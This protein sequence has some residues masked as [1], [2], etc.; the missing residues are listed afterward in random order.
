MQ[1]LTWLAWLFCGWSGLHHI[2]LELDTHAFLWLTTFDGFGFGLLRDLWRIPSYVDEYNAEPYHMA[3]VRAKAAQRKRPSLGFMRLIGQYIVGSWYGTVL[4][5]VPPEDWS[6]DGLLGS[7][8]T[9]GAAEDGD[10]YTVL[11]R[12]DLLDIHILAGLFGMAVGVYLVGSL[13][14]H[15][16]GKF[17]FVLLGAVFGQLLRCG[18]LPG[19]EQDPLAPGDETDV[20]G[21]N[22]IGAIAGFYLSSGW[23]PALLQQPEA[24]AADRR[25]SGL[26]FRLTCVLGCAALFWMAAGLGA[27]EHGS[28]TINDQETGQ[29]T[30]IKI[31]ELVGNVLAS[32]AVQQF[33][34]AVGALYSHLL[35]FGWEE[36]L[37]L[38][39]EKL[40]RTND[41][42]HS[43]Y[44]QQQHAV[45]FTR[46]TQ[47]PVHTTHTTL[48]CVRTQHA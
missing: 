39:K 16:R 33:T 45:A 44:R 32:P 46:H 19:I 28:I 38:L 26:C 35:E 18:L 34:A 5:C 47:S 12:R 13:G 27:Y 43:T 6:L 1:C 10:S 40:V 15:V 14:P 23:D 9:D 37:K 30:T 21:Y 2:L 17:S 48:V 36:T 29:P 42:I 41:Y 31:K 25:R 7:P 20:S 22:V 3:V 11:L 4:S 24:A 8:S